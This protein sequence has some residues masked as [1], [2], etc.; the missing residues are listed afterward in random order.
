MGIEGFI[1]QVEKSLERLVNLN[2]VT[3]VGSAKVEI[4]SEQGSGASTS[5]ELTGP[6]TKVIWTA[7]NLAQGDVTTVIDPDFQ[8]DGGRELREFHKS[9]ESQGLEIIRGNISALK[10]LVSL[11]GAAY[12]HENSHPAPPKR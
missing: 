10:E 5:I 4:K 11:L 1:K 8:G 2:V 9:R 7:I 6:S 12:D 3:A